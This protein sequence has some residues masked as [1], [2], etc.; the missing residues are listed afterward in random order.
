MERFA[1]E[2][3]ERRHLHVEIDIKQRTRWVIG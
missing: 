2:A 1:V 3:R